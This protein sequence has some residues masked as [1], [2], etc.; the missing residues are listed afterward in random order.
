MVL[1]PSSLSIDIGGFASRTSSTGSSGAFGL[2]NGAGAPAR[3]ARETESV[4]PE[5]ERN[6]GI[7]DA[8]RCHPSLFF[9]RPSGYALKVNVIDPHPSHSRSRGRHSSPPCEC[10]SSIGLLNCAARCTSSFN[11]AARCGSE[12]GFAFTCAARCTSSPSGAPA[13]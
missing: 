1:A 3:I 5:E 4:I 13:E 9:G 2:A 6:R 8:I 11:C 12:V 7:F 10:V